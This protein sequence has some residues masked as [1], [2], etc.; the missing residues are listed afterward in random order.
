MAM[1]STD[2]IDLSVSPSTR[3]FVR[4]GIALNRVFH[5]SSASEC[6][7]G[8]FADN[9]IAGRAVHSLNSTPG[10]IRFCGRRRP[11]VQAQEALA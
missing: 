7:R 1:G 2:Y 5:I 11:S 6:G 4:A 8:P 9:S 3:P 10:H